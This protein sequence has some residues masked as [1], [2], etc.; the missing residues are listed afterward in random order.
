MKEKSTKN[1]TAVFAG[2]CFWCTE[3]LF[4]RLKGVVSAVPG[5]TGG[6]A[7]NPTYEQVCGGATGYAEAAKIVFDPSVISYEDLLTIFFFTHDPTTLNRQGNDVGTQYRSAIF[8]STP[9]QKATVE[10]F[11]K[12][13]TAEGAYD[14]PIVTEVVPFDIFYEAEDYHKNYYETHK[15][16]PYCQIV[17]GPKVEKL[18]KKYMRLLKDL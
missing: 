3:T 18:E 6:T 1:E 14:K 9:E 15:D 12:N 11:I 10:T 8:Y 13:L 17:I 7:P 2:G 16:A 4:A 5:Y